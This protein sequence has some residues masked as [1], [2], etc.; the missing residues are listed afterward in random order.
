MPMKPTLPAII[1]A[2]RAGALDHAEHLFAAGGFEG[3]EEA[4]TLAVKGRLR[5]DRALRLSGEERRAIMAEAASLY[6]R[7]DALLPQ[8]YTR[9]NVATL[10][11]LSGDDAGAREM[12]ASVVDWLESDTDLAETPFYL[13]AT[14]AEALLLI[15]DTAGARAALISALEASPDNHED[16]ASTLRQLR[17]IVEAR[18]DDADWL[19]EFRPPRSL[20]FAGH[21]GVDAKNVAALADRIDSVLEEEAIG[22]G[23]GALAAGADILIAERLL[24]RGAELHVV[25]PLT[26]EAFAAQSIRPYGAEWETRFR[27]C[28]E[29]AESI[30]TT[31]TD[32]GAY[33]PLA[34]A[35][36]SDVAM[37]S[38]VLHASMMG[39][40]AV[41]LTIVDDEGGELGKGRATARDATRWQDAGRRSHHLRWPRVE[42]VQASATKPPEGRPDRR[43]AAML[44]IGFAGL[45]D[46][47]EA[48][49][50]RA[51]DELL[52][53]LR[54]V[55]A[56]MEAQP[57]IVLSNGNTR[58]AAFGTPEAAWKFACELQAHRF[59]APLTIAGH[60]ALAHWF[61]E[62][63]ALAGRGVADLSRLAGQALPGVVT[64][65]EP[66]ASALFLAAPGV[67]YA[68]PVGECE[69][70]TLFALRDG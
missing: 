14:R 56:A 59:K 17:L 42:S 63:A 67:V 70:L 39:S 58:I 1:T 64:V 48:S 13:A 40:E 37:G 35:L 60:Y 28:L 38:A 66:F 9:I 68:E 3:R 46:L 34:T 27:A 16:M 24:A 31:A 43:L 69:G 55:L 32:T 6:E 10:R 53:P 7:A 47:D 22:L 49:F 61:E 51:A 25:L 18:G 5:K 57:A 36:A 23:F 26:P 8:P 2:A 45:D 41:Q 11:L 21:M 12:A 62:P 44:Q 4:S 52:Y 30:V 20:H 65:S 54:D 19:D 15:G 29:A 33:E 50:E